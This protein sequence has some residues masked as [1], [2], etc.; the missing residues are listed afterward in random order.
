MREISDFAFYTFGVAGVGW[1]AGHEAYGAMIV[2]VA[3]AF[4]G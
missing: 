3:I 1:M 4:A 2:F